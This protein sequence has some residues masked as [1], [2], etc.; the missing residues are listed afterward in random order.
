MQ[1][2]QCYLTKNNCYRINKKIT[3]K[4]IMWHST[5]ANNPNLKRYVQPDDG[6]L[7]V[8]KN[9]NHWNQPEPDGRQVCVHAF[10]GKDKNG[11]IATYQTLPWNTRGWHCGAVR[12]NDKYIGFEICEDDLSNKDYFN[13]VYKEACELTAYLCKMFNLDPTKDGVVIC[14]SEGYKRGIASNHSDVM[15]WFKKFDKDMDDVR[16]DVKALMTANSKSTDSKS[17][18]GTV[19][20]VQCGAFTDKENAEA[21]VAKLKKDGYDC[22]ITTSKSSATVVT[23]KKGDKVRVVKGAKSYDGKSIASF[24]YAQTYTVHSVSGSRA[25]IGASSINTAFNTKDLIKV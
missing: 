13:K 1:L 9:G 21:L 20:K 18:S 17:T 8:N 23:I 22:Y 15:H 4:G 6:N 11:S 3:V 10:I 12:G 24:V 25:V 14:H 2:R 7:G 5:G 16:K 19:Y